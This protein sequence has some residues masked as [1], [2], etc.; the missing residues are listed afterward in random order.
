MSSLLSQPVKTFSI[1][2]EEDDYSD[3]PYA[4]QIAR[5]F[6]TDHHEFVVRPDLVSVLPE[7]V[8]AIDEPFADD[9]SYLPMQMHQ[10]VQTIKQR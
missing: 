5:R 1:G 6:S 9:C 3:L 4:W 8:W 7:V 2:F 10:P